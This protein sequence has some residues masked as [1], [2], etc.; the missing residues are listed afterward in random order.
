MKDHS[1]PRSW[2]TVADPAAARAL[3]DLEMRRILALFMIE[4]RTVKA[5]AD[6]LKV[7]INWL[8]LRVRRLEALGL[9]RVAKEVPRAGRAIKHYVATAQGFFVPYTVTPFESPEAWLVQDFA[10]RERQLALSSMQAGLHW[11]ETRGQ[12]QFG[13]RFFRREDGITQTDFAFA[14]T[15]PANLLA[16]DAPAVMNHFV[17]VNL[18]LNA[19]KALQQ[20]LFEVLQRHEKSSTGKR[21]LLRLAM[22]PI[23]PL[24]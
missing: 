6:E 23:E 14:P 21:Y 5:V 1:P 9:L 20:E 4:E 7:G 11:G 17:Y 24:V 10:A 13:K 19:A 16:P 18:E 15:E 12:A 2:L 8:L 22:A 3:S